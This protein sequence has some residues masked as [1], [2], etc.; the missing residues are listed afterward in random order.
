MVDKLS[1]FIKKKR[2]EK[3]YNQWVKMNGLPP[4]EVPQD[5]KTVPSADESDQEIYAADEDFFRSTNRYNPG[6]RFVSLPISYILLGAGVIAILLILTAILSTV[7]IMQ[8]C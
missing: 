8:G 4:E 2:G 6:T 3:L 1:G 5:S 7:L